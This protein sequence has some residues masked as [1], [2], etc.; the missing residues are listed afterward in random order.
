MT[1]TAKLIGIDPQAWLA[2]TLDCIPNYLITRID[3]IS[4]WKTTSPGRS[5]RTL[6]AEYH[7]VRVEGVQRH[8]RV[9]WPGCKQAVVRSGLE[10][11]WVRQRALWLSRPAMPARLKR[12]TR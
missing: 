8:G 12:P 2:G 1:K 7:P 5:D 6:T 11:E 4:P 3:G 10:V 9:I